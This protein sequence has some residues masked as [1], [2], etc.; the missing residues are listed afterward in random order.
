MAQRTI[1]A[2]IMAAVAIALLALG[3]VVLA[4]AICIIICFAVY[5]EFGALSKAGHR[6][7]AWPTWVGMALSV[8]MLALGGA[9]LLL[10]LALG[11]SLLTLACVIFRREPHLEDALVSLLPFI[12]LALPGMGMLT[13]TAISPKSIQ[14]T[15]LCLLIAIPCV[16]DIFA[17]YVGST[18]RGPKLCPAVSP[19]KTISGAIGGLVG[20]LVASLIVGLVAYLF[21]VQSRDLLP[22]VLDYIMLGII[23]GAAGQLG[24]LFASM[25]KRHCGIKD[26]SNLFPGHGGMLDRLDSV[27][28]MAVVMFCYRILMGF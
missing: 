17:L 25:I 11:V 6:P 4:A 21:A 7:V 18:L 2:A 26:F 22:G 23:G 8:P 5:E 16:G 13:L 12:S 27:I 1:T 10:P 14:L 28:F 19:N 24:D 15:Y 9:T 3:G 20:S